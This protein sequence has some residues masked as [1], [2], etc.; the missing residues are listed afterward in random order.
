MQTGTVLR[1]IV[2]MVQMKNSRDV[3]TFMHSETEQ[4]KKSLKAT[5]QIRNE[6][7][8]IIAMLMQLQEETHDG[9]FL[10]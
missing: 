10:C 9:T 3:D 4:L 2:V 1:D 5:K 6:I 8:E 7:K